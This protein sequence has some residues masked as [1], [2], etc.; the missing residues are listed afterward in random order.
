MGRDEAALIGRRLGEFVIRKP[1]SGGGFGMVFKAEQ[2]ALGR[3]AVVKVLHEHHASNPN[4][5]QRFLREA[6]LASLLDHP[7]AA[8]TYAFGAEPDG[9]LWIAM[10]LVRGTPL[11]TLLRVQGPIP[12]ERFAPLLGR[13]CEVVQTAHEQGIVHRDLKPA[14]VMVL[15]RAGQLLPKLLDFGIAKLTSSPAEEST[16]VAMT[17]PAA[18]AALAGGDPGTPDLRLTADGTTMGSPRYMAPEQWTDSAATDARTDIYAL[19]VMSFEALTGKPPFLAASREK[20]GAM[21][22]R[23]PVPPLGP[24]FPSGLDAVLARAMAKRKG[25][26]YQSALELAAAF[27]DASGVVEQVMLPRLDPA[28]REAAVSGA[29]QPLAL[30]VVALEAARN[31]HQ[32]RDSMWQITRVAVRLVACVALAAHAHVGPESADADSALGVALR[33]LRERQLSDAVWLEVA[34]ELVRGFAALR[35]A[36]PV[37]ELVALLTDS[38]FTALDELVAL[39][40][41]SEEAGVGSEEQVRE[42]LE[43]GLAIT[44][45]ALVELEFLFGYP[46]VVPVED[47]AITMR[48]RPGRDLAAVEREAEVSMGA[49]G[50]ARPRRRVVGSALLTGRPALIDERG[51]PV[52]SLWPFVQFHE[53]APGTPAAL[54]FLDGLGRRGARLV[55][56]PDAFEVEDEE[57]W[58]ALGAM[59]RDT[60]RER[61]EVVRDEVC[62]FPGLVAFTEANADCFVGREREAEAFLNRLRVQPLLVI[63]GPS[64]AG[65]SS[66]VQAG[67]L[68]DLPPGWSSV[69]SRPGVEPIASLEARLVAAGVPAGDLR[70]RLLEDL[71]ALGDLLRAGRGQGSVLV[72]VIDQLEELFTLCEDAGERALYAAA[73]ARAARSSDDPVRVV[74]TVRDDFLVR[75]EALPGWRS[76]IGPGLQILTTPAE[77]ELRRILVEPLRRAGYQ[78]DDEALADEM[79]A[80]VAGT[81]G[82][83][84]LLSFTANRLW[85]LRDRRFR[86][87]HRKAY[88]SLGGVAGALAQHAEATLTAM[89]SEEQ[90]LVREVFR[91]AVTGEGTRA[92]LSPIE[93]GEVLGGGPHAAAVI[94][95]LVAARLLVVSDSELGERIE[96]AHETLLS[97]WPRLV[98]WRREDTEGA[99]LRDLLRTAAR[100]WEERGRPSGLLWRGD[101]LGEY[102]QW[103]GRYPGALTSTEESFAAASLGEAA[104]ARRLRRLLVAG[105]FVIMSGVAVALLILNTRAERQRALALASKRD[106][107][108]GETDMKNLL[109]SQYE[110]QGRKLVVSDD[111]LQGLAFLAE[112]AE[113]GASGA[114]HDFAVAQA[115]QAS[116]GEQLVLRHAATVGRVRFSPDG[117]R[118]V[119]TVYDNTARMWD[120]RS[121]A[122][123]AVLPHDSAVLRVAFSPDGAIVATGEVDN[124]VKLWR[125]EDA[126]LLHILEIPGA[127]QAVELSPDGSRVLTCATSDGVQLWDA[128]T[129]AEVATLRPP[130][131]A[132]ATALGSPAAFSPDGAMVAAGDQGGLLRVWDARSGR[133]IAAMTGHTNRILWVRFS[134]DGRRLVTASQDDTAAVWNLASRRRELLLRHRGDV[135]S[136]AFSPDGRRIATASA[137]RTAVVWDA[138]SGERLLTLGGHVAGVNHAVYSPDGRKIA[139]TSDDATL[140]VWDAESGDRLAR[141]VGHRAAIRDLVFTVDGA[142]MASASLDGSAIVWTTEPALRQTRLDGHVPPVVAADV[143]PKGGHVATGDADGIA[144]VWDVATGKELIAMRGHTEALHAVKFSPDGTSL[145]T[146]GGDRTIRVWRLRDGA[147]ETVIEGHSTGVV[148]LAWTP[149]GQKLVSGS[150]D[151]T[152]RVWSATTGERLAEL[153]GHQGAV[154]DVAALPS[155]QV[156]ATSAYDNTTRLWDVASG[157]ELARFE[158]EDVRY[159]VAFDP[160]GTRAVSATSK[161]SAKIWRVSDGAVLAE[162]VGHVGNVVKAQW[163]PG[164]QLV[165]TASDDGTA[166]VWDPETG[167]VTGVFAFGGR[168]ATAT[169]SPDGGYLLMAGNHPAATITAL[170]RYSASPAD[171]ERLLRCRVPYAVE[172]ERVVPRARDFSMCTHTATP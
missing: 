90:R 92:V 59:L 104:R 10:E 38:D 111:P 52:L 24:G 86:Q 139:T 98:T 31:A 88:H 113:L 65:K 125:A 91:H 63:A 167:D 157:R 76:R 130:S 103:R 158:D 32:A 169:F 106:A 117:A 80:D 85:D 134:A 138:T 127:A 29:P 105:A 102:R 46:L 18:L 49:R 43:D 123:L 39:R 73:V 82:A 94:E 144:R 69:V 137:D 129:G 45:K 160:G 119:T 26:R 51:V 162:L 53:P 164:G 172:R 145:A 7:Y 163:G 6:R 161:Q 47:H 89:P 4:T 25:E 149:D 5:V 97:A 96:V 58:I 84:A 35:D 132:W 74:M 22:A 71:D 34:R 61:G 8:H 57:P 136:A 23:S 156:V 75:A 159:S 128:R 28:V 108:A 142:R 152:V 37:P 16:A 95:K 2:S 33:R 55:A 100:Q 72:L 13:I 66:F 48:Q 155:G 1:L 154:S 67:V 141:R 64:G 70:Q 147:V 122:P 78:L 115:V 44:A 9:V 133:A 116:G 21:H 87:L 30:A 68:P 153:S 79:I 83:L 118:L 36:H 168:V 166:R 114:G 50:G 121:G 11:D 124:R 170:P 93:L 165:V 77:P 40:A 14:N 101:A 120:A 41:E 135:G 54:F 99:Q 56:L 143:A 107:E 15:A 109:R 81:P 3:E 148:A 42:L 110:R 171:F 19:G 126:R 60:S 20:V 12:L 151:G 27:R 112:A 150:F 62:P 140:Q 146:A 17:T 131:E